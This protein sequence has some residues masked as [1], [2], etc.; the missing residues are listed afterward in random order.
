MT[1]IDLTKAKQVVGASS[2]QTVNEMIDK[3]WTLIATASGKDESDYPLITY[4]LAWFQ[5]GPPQR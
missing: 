2:P 5:E 4:S 3:G 1:N